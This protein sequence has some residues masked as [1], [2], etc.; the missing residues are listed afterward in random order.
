MSDITIISLNVKGLQS[1][2]KRRDIFNYLRN[3][4]YSIIFLQETHSSEKD[5]KCWTAEW[6]HKCFFSH[7]NTNSAGVMILFQNNFEY[8]VKNIIRDKSGRYIVMDITVEH[9][10]L[11]IVNLYGPNSLSFIFH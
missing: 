10:H 4:K 3:K 2:Q 7:G 8:S 1:D 9:Y 11:S 5:E 6:G